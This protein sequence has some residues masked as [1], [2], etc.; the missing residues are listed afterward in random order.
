MSIESGILMGV[1]AFGY[2][3]VLLPLMSGSAGPKISVALSTSVDVIML[4][5]ME[6]LLRISLT[7][8]VE[9][10]P[11]DSCNILDVRAP[12]ILRRV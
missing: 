12:S 9:G 8:V 6:L 5:L 7:K 10:H 3:L 1:C 2:F 4:F 11:M